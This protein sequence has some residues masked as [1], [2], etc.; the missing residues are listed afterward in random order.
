MDISSENAHNNSSHEALPLL[1]ITLV[2]RLNNQSGS[3]RK[4]KL[5]F[6]YCY[7]NGLWFRHPEYHCLKASDVIRDHSKASNVTRSNSIASVLIIHINND[8]KMHIQRKL[9]IICRKGQPNFSIVK[10]PY[11]IPSSLNTISR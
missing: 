2:I 10:T 6:F 9:P 7:T 8:T 11:R 3:V 5:I 4:M 1:V